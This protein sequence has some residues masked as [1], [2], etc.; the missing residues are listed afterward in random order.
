MLNVL[1]IKDRVGIPH[2]FLRD[3]RTQK[4]CQPA[5]VGAGFSTVWPVC[6]FSIEIY[7]SVG[8]EVKD[9]LQSSIVGIGRPIGIAPRCGTHVSAFAAQRC[10]ASLSGTDQ[11][12]V[13]ADGVHEAVV[14]P[15]ALQ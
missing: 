4:S 15:H 12:V 5:A 13:Q 2:L 3:R 14:T 11:R 6:Q 10:P 1:D 7:S 8:T 9:L